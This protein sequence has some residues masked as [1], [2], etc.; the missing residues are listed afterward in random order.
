MGFFCQEYTRTSMSE[1]FCLKWNDFHSNASKSFGILRNEDYLHDVTLVGD[2]L[3]HVSAHK[4]VL[5]ASS[6]YFKN[7]FKLNKHSHPLICLDGLSSTDLNNI[8]DY[9][10][11]GEIQIYQDH[12]DKFLTIA[13]RLKLEGLISDN[14]N[15][16][17]NLPKWKIPFKAEQS[18]NNLQGNANQ[19]ENQIQILPDPV[20]P[21]EL[22]NTIY[23]NVEK[24]SDGTYS[25]K[26]C[27]KVSKLKPNMKF[28]VETHLSGLSFP[29]NICGKNYRSRTSLRVHQYQNHK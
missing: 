5:S 7:I 13:H 2:D 22:D 18:D 16:K 4:L 25:C 10:Y 29:C 15:L 24:N 1:K 17:F 12:L 21:N 9:I 6:D 19:L 27:S 3:I 14:L 26:F 20:D 8:L 11:N 28:H 23:E